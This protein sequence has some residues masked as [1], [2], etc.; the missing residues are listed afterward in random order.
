MSVNDTIARMAGEGRPTSQIAEAVGLSVSTVKRRRRAL[1]CST[2]EGAPTRISRDSVMTLHKLDLYTY[3]QIA[4]KVGC[5][6]ARVA[7]IIAE[8]TS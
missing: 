7:Q 8:E 4:N 1:G 5:S 6:H 2:R 3:Q